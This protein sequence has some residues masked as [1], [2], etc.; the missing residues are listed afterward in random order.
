MLKPNRAISWL[1]LLAAAA[2]V[3]A[4]EETPVLPVNNRIV[5]EGGQAIGLGEIGGYE[6]RSER[7]AR[8]VSGGGSYNT[9]I[10]TGTVYPDSYFYE[11]DDFRHRRRMDADDRFRMR[12]RM[13]LEEQRREVQRL[14]PNTNNKLYNEIVTKQRMEERRNGNL[15]RDLHRH[16]EPY[17]DGGRG[18]SRI[19]ID[20]ER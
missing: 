11:D 1:S 19:R 18:G 7:S 14:S 10:E 13:R 17:R 2:P 3:W 16:P 6:G 5:Y 9:R 15:D 8:I 12:N 4:A 20:I